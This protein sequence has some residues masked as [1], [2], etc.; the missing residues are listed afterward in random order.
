MDHVSNIHGGEV[1]MVDSE[2]PSRSSRGYRTAADFAYDE[3][4]TRIIDGLVAPGERIDQEEE[5]RR[6]DLSR[7][8]VRE[9]LRRLSADGLVIIVPNRGAQVRSLSSEDLVDL[10]SLR[11]ALET[12]ASL[13]GTERISESAVG[14]MMA[15]LPQMDIVAEQV[16][17]SSWIDLD[18]RFHSILYG[19]TGYKRL[20]GQID[21]YRE[22][23]RRYRMV[24]FKLPEELGV[25]LKSHYVIV[26][27]IKRR[28]AK[29]VSNVVRATLERTRNRLLDAVAKNSYQG[30][31][32]INNDDSKPS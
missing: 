9:A 31:E 19:A 17:L 18:R 13:L 24:A 8:P 6:L 15:L 4:R 16:D 12:E 2:M 27:A 10:Y 3:I 23:A 22:E 11:I 32:E 25:S 20:V 21:Q 1:G 30:S 14:G 7:T 28:D 5:A 26:D 29:E